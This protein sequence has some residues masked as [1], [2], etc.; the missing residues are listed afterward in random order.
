MG[1]PKN[2]ITTDKLNIKKLLESNS[3]SLLKLNV[4]TS[5]I[6]IIPLILLLLIVKIPIKELYNYLS[7]IVAIIASV[8][9]QYFTFFKKKG[10]L[11]LYGDKEPRYEECRIFYQKYR[12]FAIDNDIQ[13][14]SISIVYNEDLKEYLFY[15]D[16]NSKTPYVIM[17]STSSDEFSIILVPKDAE[18]PKIIEITYSYRIP[19]DNNIIKEKSIIKRKEYKN[20]K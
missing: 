20:A 4:I 18:H 9:V 11:I 3:F 17:K 7:S 2:I 8:N 19:G 15:P 16:I 1:F 10:R 5:I 12:L 14:I 6:C 13:F